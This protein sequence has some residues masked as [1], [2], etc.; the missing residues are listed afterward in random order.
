MDRF[1]DGLGQRWARSIVIV[2]S[3][4]VAILNAQAVFAAP[5]LYGIVSTS[6]FGP[7]EFGSLDPAT[8]AFTRIGSATLPAGGYY[9]PVYDPTR[10]V[11]YVTSVPFS[12]TTKSEFFAEIDPD[13]GVLTQHQLGFFQFPV[14]LGVDTTTG[15]L[16]GIVSTS[17]FGPSEFGSIDP[18]TDTY[19]R[20]GSATL[21]AGGYYAPVYDPTRDVFY[22]TSVPFSD[23]TKSE[24]F[25]EID[26]D[27]GV[28]TPRH[29][30]FFQFPVGL[31]LGGAA[32]TSVPEP[33]SALQL[34]AGVVG[35]ALVASGKLVGPFGDARPWRTD[36]AV[37]DP[38]RQAVC[39][40]PRLHVTVAQ[41]ICLAGE[42]AAWRSS[43]SD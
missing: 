13:T 7:S 11:F 26:A 24:F 27:T 34:L 33:G 38:K 19:T 12:N 21:P 25:D 28:I 10:N 8:G 22:V 43:S 15:Q 35:I 23:S 36:R 41:V 20:I 17:T 4:T 42:F 16:Y 2:A 9:A 18:A 40:Q 32:V 31:G 39:G 1:F 14:G 6:T 5:T 37:P 29:V 3:A 30:G